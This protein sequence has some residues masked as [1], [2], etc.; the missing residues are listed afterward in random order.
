MKDKS[1]E[2]ILSFTIK[3]SIQNFRD[4]KEENNCARYE[5]MMLDLIIG[6]FK[7][8]GHLEEEDYKKL[9]CLIWDFVLEKG[10]TAVM[11]DI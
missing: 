4:T 8:A 2:E 3:E 10:W 5:L 7:N 1:I 9:K 6:R 11:P